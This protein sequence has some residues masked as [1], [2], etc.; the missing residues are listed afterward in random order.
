MPP[1]FRHPKAWWDERLEGQE[2]LA[3]G[4][5][6]ICPAH[7]DDGPSLHVTDK[8]Q[9]KPPVL[10]CFAGC[11][12]SDIERAARSGSSDDDDDATAPRVT[13]SKAQR[14]PVVIPKGS[15]RPLSWL[16]DYTGVDR[17]FLRSLGIKADG[18]K[19]VFTFPHNGIA[20]W[21]VASSDT[22]AMGWNKKGA[23]TPYLWPMPPEELPSTIYLTEGESDCIILRF[24]KYEA[25]AITHGAKAELP[26]AVLRLLRDRGVAHIVLAFDQDPTGEAAIEQYTSDVI[27]AGMSVSTLRPTLR[28]L[29]GESDLRDWYLRTGG[30]GGIDETQ[31]AA[32]LD[33]DALAAMSP[34]ETTWITPGYFAR[35]AITLVS[36]YPKSGKS[37]LLAYFLGCHEKGA[38]FLGEATRKGTA[39]LMTEEFA[40]TILEKVHRFGV[41]DVAVM[42]QSY[43][44]QQGWTFGD[45]LVRAVSQARREKRDVLMIDTLSAWAQ[46]KD[47]NDASEVTRAMTQVRNATGGSGLSV[48]LVH[49]LR[50]GGGEHGEAIRGSGAL[51]ALSEVS[52][53]YGFK[54]KMTRSVVITSRFQDVPAPAFVRMN[55]HGGL[56]VLDQAEWDIEEARP[57][58]EA[59]REGEK[60]ITELVEAVDASEPTIRKHLNGLIMLEQVSVE[61]GARGKKTYSLVDEGARAGFR[62]RKVRSHA[63]AQ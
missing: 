54:D 42:T 58:I 48:V 4:Y 28:L 32:A 15:E 6:A 16:A 20:K 55:D 53:E 19:V 8:G 63:A 46:F 44:A 57:V 52:I 62:V 36:G 34:E 35:D 60:T 59:L 41:S 17:A 22:K 23:F 18:D 31:G 37:S 33:L 2:T 21:R 1:S 11:S 49:H 14:T 38:S 45:A 39:L 40:P 30:E 43:A 25:F 10:H 24:L 47:E 27:D 50:K 56:E 13:K 9:G 5:K 51:F 61:V 26:Q 7:D 3:D 29:E 12:Y